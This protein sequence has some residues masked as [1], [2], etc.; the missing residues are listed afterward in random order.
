MLHGC[1]VLT[2]RAIQDH[3]DQSSEHIAT[4]SVFAKVSVA[5]RP[6]LTLREIVF[7][8]DVLTFVIL[9][10]SRKLHNIFI[11]SFL[12]MVDMLSVYTN[13]K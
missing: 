3:D 11:I 1:Q 5:G 4:L 7:N 13:I 2:D 6:K 9:S 10:I 12:E 8:I